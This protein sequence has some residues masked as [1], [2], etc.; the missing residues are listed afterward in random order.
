MVLCKYCDEPVDKREVEEHYQ[1]YHAPVD[2]D[3]CRKKVPADKLEDHKVLH[4]HGIYRV[5]Y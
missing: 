4:V 1:E 2:C 5:W 3:I